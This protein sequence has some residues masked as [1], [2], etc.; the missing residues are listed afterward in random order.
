VAEA[1][2]QHAFLVPWFKHDRP[3]IIGQVAAAVRKV[4]LGARALLP[5]LPAVTA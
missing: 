1:V 2:K 4:A 5:G 3:E